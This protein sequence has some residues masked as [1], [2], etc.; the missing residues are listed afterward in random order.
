MPKQKNHKGELGR[1]YVLGNGKKAS[2]PGIERMQCWE[3]DA[4]VI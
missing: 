2:A 3:T 4:V 1:A